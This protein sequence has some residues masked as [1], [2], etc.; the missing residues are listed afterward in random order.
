M[1]KELKDVDGDMGII[2]VDPRG[3]FAME[4]NSDRMHRAWR[5]SDNEEGAYNYRDK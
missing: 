3:N 2:A 5:S 1:N 4:F